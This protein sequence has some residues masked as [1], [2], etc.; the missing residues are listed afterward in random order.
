MTIRRYLTGAW[1]TLLAMFACSYGPRPENFGPA[2]TPEG[3]Q[4]TV[5]FAQRESLTGELL[6]VRDSSMVLLVGRRVTV[7]RFDAI[8]GAR[9]ESLPRLELRRRRAPEGRH[10]DELRLVSRFPYGLTPEIEAALLAAHGQERLDLIPQ[11]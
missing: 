5:Y 4:A 8:A 6:A 9:F 10:R 1:A 7:V 11:Q 2:R 3:V